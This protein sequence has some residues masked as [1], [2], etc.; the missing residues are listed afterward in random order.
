MH[1][2]RFRQIHLD[3]HTSPAIENIGA[4]FDK[5]QWQDMLKKGHVNS[6]TTFAVGHHGWN[7]HETKVGQ[8][9]PHLSFDLLRAQF[10]AAKEIDVNV[11]VYITAGVHNRMAYEHPE[12][13]EVGADGRYTG[14]ARNLT[15]AGFHKMCFNTPYLDWLCAQI[16]EVIEQYPNADGIFLDI[17]SQ[18]QCCCKWCIETMHAHGLDPRNEV[19]RKKNAKM[20][21]RKYYERTTAAARDAKESMPVFHNSGHIPRGTRDILPF[22]SHLELE[23]LPTGG[24]GYDHFP[25]SAKYCSGLDLDFLGMTGKFHTTWGEFGGYKHPNALRYE[26]AAMLAFGAK[27]SVGDQLHPSGVMDESTYEIIGAAYADVE[28]KENWCS[29]VTTVSDIGLLSSEAFHSGRENSADTG[30]GRLLLENHFLFD[31]LDT[32]SD[33]SAY[34]IIMLPDDI[35]V[36]GALKEKLTTYISDGGSLFMTGASGIDDETQEPVF[37]IGATCEGIS[38]FQPDFI[39]PV[40]ELQPEFIASPMVMYTPSHRIRVTDGETLGA[41]YDPYFNRTYK[42]FCSHQHA[43][44]RPEPS[45][46]ACGVKK[47]NLLYI[48]HPLCTLY[49]AYGTVAVSHYFRKCM[50]MLLKKR[51]VETTL[52]SSG[53][54]SLM[55]Q[56][57]EKRYV[58]HLLYATPIARGGQMNLSGGTVSQAGISI[59]VIEDLCPLKDVS[60]SLHVPE[61]IQTITRVPDNVQCEFSS[62]GELLS[63]S[64]DEFTCHAMIE[65]SYA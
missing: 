28:K 55:H 40:P 48:A 26:C 51:T 38:P 9:H 30:A 24:W 49:A 37:D 45:G 1:S 60:V 11:P 58:L 15:D 23:S 8:M 57:E 19:D 61:K 17:I 5:K 62:E 56:P 21:L 44:P 42:H 53:R 20:T 43:P 32:E 16:Q 41:V 29:N 65:L 31:V 34:K 63:F 47:G 14:W 22:F 12:W 36:T 25:L 54:V 50:E 35:P 2:L 64:L 3:F 27:C 6:V 18:G 46:F 4:S 13:R 52:P 10:D 39:L 33:F 7:Y 59:E